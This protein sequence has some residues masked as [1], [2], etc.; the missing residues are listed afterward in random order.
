M[1]ALL[2]RTARDGPRLD[3]P[4]QPT[5]SAT[6][7]HLKTLYAADEAG[8]AYAYSG[9]SLRSSC[10]HRL[11]LGSLG[12]GRAGAVEVRMR[13]PLRRGRAPRS[14]PLLEPRFTLGAL[15]QRIFLGGAGAA[16]SKQAI[17]LMDYVAN[18]FDSAMLLE[19]V[20]GSPP[21]RVVLVDGLSSF[22]YLGGASLRGEAAVVY[23][24][25]DY[26]PDFT[27]SRYLS[28]VVRRK[29][30]SALGRS[31]LVLAASERDRLRYLSHGGLDPGRALVLPNIF[32]P[33]GGAL[34]EPEKAPT[35]TIAVVE[36]GWSGR[37]GARRDALELAEA[38]LLLPRDVPVRVVAVGAELARRLGELLRGRAEV[39][40]FGR[41]PSRWEFLRLLSS[42]H[43]GVNLGRWTGGTNTKKYDY[44][45]AGDVVVTNSLGARGETLP[46]QVVF[47]G[48]SDLSS[49][50]GELWGKGG[51]AL[52]AM[53]LENRRAARGAAEG[54]WARLGEAVRRAAGQG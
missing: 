27:V 36:T 19:R 42:A 53:G 32:V 18:G 4:G 6:L 33:E 2:P 52:E 43:V 44:A 39:A 41:L 8:P 22:A 35:F 51:A 15:L 28:G 26:E 10:A 20:R 16:G 37:A 7:F 9:S 14:G 30:D 46:H 3:P 50:L 23:L 47:S 40:G 49:K 25:H 34:P 17:F 1:R 38:I 31:D 12:G 48:E 45:L 21:P 24:S 29:I 11:L 5:H 13:P 54:A